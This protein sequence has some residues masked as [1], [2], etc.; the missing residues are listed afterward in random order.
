MHS[1]ASHFSDFCAAEQQEFNQS[2]DAV[3]AN[4]SLLTGEHRQLHGVDPRFQ[5]WGETNV[6]GTFSV[7]FYNMTAPRGPHGYLYYSG[8]WKERTSGSELFFLPNSYKAFSH[9]TNHWYRF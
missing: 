6:D 8:E 9:F 5:V 2:I 7:F 4:R 3:I 1:P